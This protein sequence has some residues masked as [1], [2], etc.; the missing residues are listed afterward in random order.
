[1]NRPTVKVVAVAFKEVISAPVIQPEIFVTVPILV[2]PV[3]ESLKYSCV[4]QRKYFE[5]QGRAMLWGAVSPSTKYL[6]SK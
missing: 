1:L 5:T 4:Y 2:P 3:V 6:L